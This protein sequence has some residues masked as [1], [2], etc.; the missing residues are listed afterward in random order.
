MPPGG[1]IIK[2]VTIGE[3]CCSEKEIQD[4]RRIKKTYPPTLP[5]P[6]WSLYLV[7]IFYV[8]METNVLD[9]EYPVE[10]LSSFS[11]C[12]IR[13]LLLIDFKKIYFQCNFN[14]NNFAFRIQLMM[15]LWITFDY[16]FFPKVKLP[17]LE[18]SFYFGGV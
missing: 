17:F 7:S 6:D 18:I 8:R 1:N 11:C 3:F 10:F 15:D 5:K 2:R 9:K 16:C 4:N 13:L 12:K 14:L